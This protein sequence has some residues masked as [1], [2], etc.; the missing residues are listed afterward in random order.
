[1]DQDITSIFVDL[2]YEDPANNYVRTE[3]LALNKANP[4]MDWSIPVISE[5]GGKVTYS[6]S[7][8]HKDGTTEDIPPTEAKTNTIALGKIPDML[9]VQVLPDL[10]DF[11]TVKLAKISLS[12]QDQANG[13]DERKDVI[14]KPDSAAVDWILKLK[15]KSKNSY[16]WQVTFFM[17]DGSTKKTDPVTTSEPTVLPEVSAAH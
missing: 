9:Q 3:S 15:D 7:I 11:S 5:T 2:K 8:Q 1:M 10:I 14:F 17:K 4:F 12:Y 6:G 16:Q 13:I